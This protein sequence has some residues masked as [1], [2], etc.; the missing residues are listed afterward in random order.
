MRT[1][2]DEQAISKARPERIF[3][4]FFVTLQ[5]MKLSFIYL[6]NE[7]YWHRTGGMPTF[8]VT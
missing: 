5:K 4:K 2:Y 3:S 8:E 7:M 1:S 6:A